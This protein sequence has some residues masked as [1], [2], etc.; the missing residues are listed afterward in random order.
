[1]N[2]WG[3]L[4]APRVRTRRVICQAIA[5]LF[6]AVIALGA[7]APLASAHRTRVT[8]AGAQGHGYRQGVVPLRGHQSNAA[9]GSGS[10]NDLSYGGGIGGVGVTTGSPKVYLVFWGKQ[11]GTATYSGSTVSL[12]SGDPKAMAPYLERFI[13]GLGGGS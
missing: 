6:F 9:S 4:G 13:E 8:P 11:W 5:G 12:L 2:S 10:A 3:Q 1:M 7:Y